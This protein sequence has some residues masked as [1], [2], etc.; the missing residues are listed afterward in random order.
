[1]SVEAFCGSITETLDIVLR[2]GPVPSSE[3]CLEVHQVGIGTIIQVGDVIILVVFYYLPTSA[4]SET[5]LY[6]STYTMTAISRESDT[7][8]L[9]NICGIKLTIYKTSL[10]F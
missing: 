1:M 5:I 2:R 4:E 8:N 6:V 10:F 7:S 9:E 3:S